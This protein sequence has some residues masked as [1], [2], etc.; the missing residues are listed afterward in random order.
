[1]MFVIARLS[2]A[3][4]TSAGGDVA[5]E[6]LTYKENAT[7]RSTPRHDFKNPLY[8]SAVAI[9]KNSEPR[10]EDKYPIQNVLEVPNPHYN[11]FR[12][13]FESSES[14]MEE[15]AVRP[16]LDTFPYTMDGY[17][18]D[19]EIE[20]KS[21][22]M[23]QSAKPQRDRVKPIIYE[24]TDIVP[25]PSATSKASTAKKRVQIG[26]Y[27]VI[28]TH[29]ITQGELYDDIITTKPHPQ[30]LYDDVLTDRGATIEAK[31]VAGESIEAGSS[32]PAQ[33]PPYGNVLAKTGMPFDNDVYSEPFAGG[34]LGSTPAG[35]AGYDVPTKP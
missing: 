19:D 4:S 34:P 32:I 12:D 11:Q 16:R 10:P 27:D 13:S 23:P 18:M 25:T 9:S 1:M 20:A 21:G 2:D 8:G 7:P 6:T 29:E 5:V 24:E 30:D 3:T 26:E 33:Q 35:D 14:A 22:T 31:R 28:T 17:V 15:D